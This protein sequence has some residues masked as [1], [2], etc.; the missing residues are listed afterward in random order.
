[1]VRYFQAG[2]NFVGLPKQMDVI[3]KSNHPA[4]PVGE[5]SRI[6]RL[7]VSV[8]RANP[9]APLVA[10]EGAAPGQVLLVEVGLLGDVEHQV[11]DGA[12]THTRRGA[13]LVGPL[14]ACF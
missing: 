13:L 8:E 6:T 3:D 14:E 4:V 11:P 1:M 12:G 2:T 9:H 10:K 5:N 7:S